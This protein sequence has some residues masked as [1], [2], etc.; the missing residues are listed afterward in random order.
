MSNPTDER[1]VYNDPVSH[2]AVNVDGAN[3]KSFYNQ[4]TYFFVNLTN[5]Q[6]FDEDPSLWISTPHGA[7][8]S[9]ALTPVADE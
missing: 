1:L 4:K 8:T 2:E 9:S 3:Y 5:K 6:I 7:Q